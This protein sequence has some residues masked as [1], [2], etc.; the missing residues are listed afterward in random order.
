MRP[1]LFLI[2]IALCSCG[3]YAERPVPYFNTPDFTPLFLSAS[4][5]G[6]QITHRLPAFSFTNQHGEE[7]SEKNIAGKIV[8]SDFFFSRCASICPKMTTGMKQVADAFPGNEVMLLSHSV[9]PD[10][11]SVPALK[12]F[13]DRNGITH[14]NWHLL[15]G[16]KEKIYNLARRG[17]FADE[18]MGYSADTTDFLHTENFVLLDRNGMIRGVYN[19]TLELEINNLVR[20]IRLLI[21][22]DL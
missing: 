2:V 20:D 9:T 15:T 11:D 13:A 6:D 17:Y 1:A 3:R 18:R 4:E 12:A 21:A 16:E 19:G 14:K 8:I 22:E 10:S 5:A 7:I